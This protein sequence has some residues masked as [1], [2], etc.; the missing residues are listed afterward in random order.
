MC[1]AI[2][3]EGVYELPGQP[4]FTGGKL[5]QSSTISAHRTSDCVTK[6]E[7]EYIFSIVTNIYKKSEKDKDNS[8]TTSSTQNLPRNREQ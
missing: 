5:D 4:V 3:A 2:K 7:I 6:V 1:V 8:R